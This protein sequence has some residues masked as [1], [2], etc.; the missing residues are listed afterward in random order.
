MYQAL[1]AG[2]ARPYTCRSLLQALAY[3]AALKLG[4]LF[5]GKNQ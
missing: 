2:Q 4:R 5:G 1:P 3:L